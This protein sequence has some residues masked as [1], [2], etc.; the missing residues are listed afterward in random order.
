LPLLYAELSSSNVTLEFSILRGQGGRR[1]EY[2]H[3]LRR[4]SGRG[5]KFF[6]VGEDVESKNQTPATSDV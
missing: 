2:F 3:D 4:R 6:G 1:L 5:T